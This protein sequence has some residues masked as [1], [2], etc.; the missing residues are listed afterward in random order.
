MCLVPAGCHITPIEY[1]IVD[2]H[3]TGRA[4]TQAEL[5]I[6]DFSAGAILLDMAPI[7][8]GLFVFDLSRLPAREADCPVRG[9]DAG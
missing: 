5:A 6:T 9:I 1:C 4:V 3:G 2:G 8:E 7:T